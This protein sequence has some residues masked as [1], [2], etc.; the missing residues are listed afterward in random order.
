MW[1]GLIK[2]DLPVK[3]LG[4]G[5]LGQKVKVEAHKFSKSAIEKIKKAGGSIKIIG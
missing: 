4:D 2:R 1:K 3:I 5:E